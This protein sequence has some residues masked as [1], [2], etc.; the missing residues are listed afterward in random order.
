MRNTNAAE[1]NNLRSYSTEQ[2]SRSVN[3]VN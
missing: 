1:K 2:K 3:T